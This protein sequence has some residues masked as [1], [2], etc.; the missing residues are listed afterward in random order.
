[1][2]LELM[3]KDQPNGGEDDHGGRLSAADEV[4]LF[5]DRQVVRIP[6]LGW[7]ARLHIT[8]LEQMKHEDD[9]AE[10]EECDLHEI[11]NEAQQTV[12]HIVERRRDAED[13]ESKADQQEPE[14]RDQMDTQD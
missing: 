7:P 2:R 11:P 12:R 4:P 1:M 9:D 8:S 10:R 5:G 6:V 14:P 13:E 3:E